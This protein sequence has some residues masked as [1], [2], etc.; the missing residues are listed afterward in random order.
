MLTPAEEEYLEM[1]YRHQEKANGTVKTKD[2]ARSLKIKD[3]S[4]VEMLK[5]LRRKSL[6]DYER[7]AGVKLTKKGK[8]QAIRIVRRHQLA[9]RL[10][11]DVLGHD[12][13]G[14]HEEACKLEH[15]FDDELADKIN[16]VL[17]KPDTCPHGSPIPSAEG[18]AA[19]VKAVELTNATENKE[20]TVAAI[21]EERGSLERLLSFNILPGSKIKVTEKLPRGALMVRCGDTRVALSRNIASKILVKT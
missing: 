15:A 12:L 1:I 21:P 14:V 7:Y 18:L 5:K 3:P 20:C 11:S 13:L 16:D 19:K 8:M 4:V 2:L 9:E 17:G 6:I 10:L